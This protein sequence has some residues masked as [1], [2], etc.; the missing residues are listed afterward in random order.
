MIVYAQTT[1]HTYALAYF[2]NQSIMYY[3]VVLFPQNLF[4]LE[5]YDP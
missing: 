5:P 3:D 4:S 2:N 1:E